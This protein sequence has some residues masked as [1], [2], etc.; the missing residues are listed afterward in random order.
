MSP[1]ILT[2]KS[3]T[4]KCDIWSLGI[5]FY[6]SIFGELPW[7]ANTEDEL[8]HNVMTKPLVFPKNIKISKF[9]ENFLIKSLKIEE[10]YRSSWAEIFN[11][12]DKIFEDEII[13][14]INGFKD[15]FEDYLKKIFIFRDEINFNHFL[16]FELFCN[17]KTMNRILKKNDFILEKFILMLSQ[18]NIL[19]SKNLI[20]EINMLEKKFPDFFNLKL[21]CFL[22]TLKKEEFFFQKFLNEFLE[23]L[24][25]KGNLNEIKDEKNI[26]STV[27][28]QNPLKEDEI[29]K[30]SLMIK[31]I[32]IDIAII[33][34]NYIKTKDEL[35]RDVVILIHYIIDYVLIK[36]LFEKNPNQYNLYVIVHKEKSI[37]KDYKDLFD[38]LLIKAD[39]II[40]EKENKINY[41]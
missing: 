17:L 31:F 26:K 21:K 35:T 16:A 9:S 18:L 28:P 2:R 40:K 32:A 1:Q 24:E 8:I 22:S 15:N 3:Y 23:N 13:R 5:I 34:V 14:E 12:G 33:C 38:S 27:F 29:E 10:K 30:F 25:K 11:L 39:E 7:K 20:N 19:Q 6:E 36:H 37:M 4:T 41:F